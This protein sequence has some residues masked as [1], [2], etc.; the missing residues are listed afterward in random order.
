MDG[1]EEAVEPPREALMTNSSL[2]LLRWMAD[3]AE[4][5]RCAPGAGLLNPSGAAAAASHRH[6]VDGL[7]EVSRLA[8]SPEPRALPACSPSMTGWRLCACTRM[9]WHHVAIPKWAYA[10]WAPVQLPDANIRPEP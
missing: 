3:Y 1:A 5:M 7:E 8:L 9:L 4:L 6:R 10:A 2:R